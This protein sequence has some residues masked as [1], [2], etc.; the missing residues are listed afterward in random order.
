M[1]AAEPLPDGVHPMGE[2]ANGFGLGGAVRLHPGLSHRPG[3]AGQ[4][5]WGGAANT[6]WWIDPAEQL[7][8]LLMLQYMPCFTIPIVE[9]FAQLAYQAL[10]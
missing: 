8:C 4:F 5:G 2:L 9:D 7:Q 10:E 3:S 1:D 6:E